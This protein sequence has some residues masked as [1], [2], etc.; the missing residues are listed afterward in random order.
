MCGLEA[1]HGGVTRLS[2]GTLRAHDALGDVSNAG[3]RGAAT[4]MAGARRRDD[5]FLCLA[6]Y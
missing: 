2:P 4:N 3:P 5:A 6:G 1:L